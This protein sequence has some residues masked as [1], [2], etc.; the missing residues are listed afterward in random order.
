MK[1][2][3]P[4]RNCQRRSYVNAVRYKMYCAKRGKC[5]AKQLPPCKSSLRKHVQ[6]ANYY[7]MIWR[8]ALTPM[9]DIPDPVTH[10]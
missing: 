7:C 9:V 6:R 3:F 5:E 4:L 8:E 1:L 2:T 10:E